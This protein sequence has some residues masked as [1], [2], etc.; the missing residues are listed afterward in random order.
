VTKVL[1]DAGR[2]ALLTSESSNDTGCMMDVE[3]PHTRI[4]VGVDHSQSS[5][6]A[7]LWAAEEAYLRRAHL[8]ITHVEPYQSPG[9]WPVLDVAGTPNLITAQRSLLALSAAAASMRQPAVAVGTLLFHGQIGDELVKLS[10]TAVL[11]V[12]GVDP[13]TTSSGAGPMAGVEDRL[14]ASAGCPVVTVTHRPAVDDA[15][16]QRVMVA[17][18]DDDLGRRSLAYA[19]VEA[20]LRGASLTAV[21]VRDCDHER[22]FRTMLASLQLR[23]LPPETQVEWTSGAGVED[24]IQ[25]TSTADLLVIGSGHSDQQSSQHLGSVPAAV[26]R[27]ATCPVMFVGRSVQLPSLGAG[28]NERPRNAQLIARPH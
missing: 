22:A 14:V 13:A 28:P 8:I 4:L 3:S 5:R 18:T 17:W 9:P 2:M 12:L 16:R 11:I 24:V 27:G 21:A 15:V 20:R 10:G 23:Q 19:A 6:Y 7:V 1:T 25:L 26:S